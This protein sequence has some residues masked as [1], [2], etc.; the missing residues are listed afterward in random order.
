MIYTACTMSKNEEH[1]VPAWLEATKDFD[2]RVIVDTGST[3]GTVEL[4]RASDVI[5]IEKT[6]DP[7]KFNETRN[8]VASQLPED[9]NW[10][11]WPD[12]DEEYLP[13]W[14]KE[15]EKILLETPNATRVLHKSEH[16]R[17]GVYEG[18]CESGTGI[19][20][21]IFKHNY[22]TWI[23]PIHEHPSAI[24]DE[25]VAS[26]D[27]IV[28]KHYHKDRQWV[29]DLCFVIA[30]EAAEEDPT[31]SWCMWFA[32][33]DAHERTLAMD[34]VKYGNLYLK[35][36]TPYTDFRSLAH[37]YV[38]LAFKKLKMPQH[39]ELSFLRATAEDPKN[40]E[41]RR[42]H[43]AHSGYKQGRT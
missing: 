7:F 24:L 33:R 42:L 32:L 10:V 27:L 35:Y 4:L 28:R 29:N 37:M 21:K 22:Y 39:A 36:T 30:R 12:M 20:S 1:N 9:T 6:F 34:V 13:G 43:H 16:Y 14:R 8:F 5:L 31:D 38:G 3:D 23:K 18:G 19:D 40:Q 15:M 17:N 25:V 11:F 41:A 2:H 26:T